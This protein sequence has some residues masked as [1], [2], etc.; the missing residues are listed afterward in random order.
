MEL[1]EK[2]IKKLL[3]EYTMV[4]PEIQREYVWGSDKN[5]TVLRK[6]LSELNDSLELGNSNIGFLYSYDADNNEHYIIDGQQRFT[7]IVLL[8]FYY[9]IKENK[10]QEFID[11]TK[12]NAPMMKFS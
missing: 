11:L 9:A 10:N 6:F 3:S 5:E 1:K 7:T 8:L 2:T 12:T 4:V